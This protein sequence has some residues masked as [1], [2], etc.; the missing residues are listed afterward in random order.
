MTDSGPAHGTPW[1]RCDVTPRDR[2]NNMRML[3]MLLAWA[4]L[5]LGATWL[6]ESDRIAAAPLRWALA[7]VPAIAGL[8][9]LMAFARL[10]READELQ[11]MIQLQALAVGFGGTWFVLTAYGLFERVGAPP[12]DASDYTVAMSVFYVIGILVGRRRYR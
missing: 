8:A 10:I 9:A 4:V 7:A 3:T 11:R 2:R 5:F 12:I 6:V 1:A